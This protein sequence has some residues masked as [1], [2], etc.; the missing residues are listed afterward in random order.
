MGKCAHRHYRNNFYHIRVVKTDPQT[1]QVHRMIHDGIEQ[2]DKIVQLVDDGKEHS[3][4]AEVGG[5]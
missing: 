4:V 3:A 2:Q 1:A 5:I